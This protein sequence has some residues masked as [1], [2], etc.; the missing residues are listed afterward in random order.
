MREIISERKGHFFEVSQRLLSQLFFTV[1]VLV[2]KGKASLYILGRPP[3]WLF[4]TGCGLLL[5][6]PLRLHPWAH[7]LWCVSIF[8]RF[9]VHGGGALFR[10]NH[11]NFN[12]H[13]YGFLDC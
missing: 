6:V 4:S 11:E 1:L 12:F 8:F 13:H 2:S 7:L 5:R 9:S 3:R 10:L